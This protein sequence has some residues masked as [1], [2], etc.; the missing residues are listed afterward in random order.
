MGNTRWAE[1]IF[2]FFFLTNS[3]IIKKKK[4]E[5]EKED[6]NKYHRRITN[7]TKIVIQ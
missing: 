3:R 4:K 2:F 1:E 5:I 7:S 6:L